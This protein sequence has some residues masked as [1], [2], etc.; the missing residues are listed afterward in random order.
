MGLLLRIGSD[1]SAG[2]GSGLHFWTGG[3]AMLKPSGHAMGVFTRAL[4]PD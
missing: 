1:R 2:C 3:D 4:D